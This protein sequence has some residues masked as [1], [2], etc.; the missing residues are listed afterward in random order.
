[1]K[2]LTDALWTGAPLGAADS[3]VKTAIFSANSAR[4]YGLE[5]H[6]DI[7]ARDRFA[8]KAYYRRT[9]PGRRNLHYGYVR[10]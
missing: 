10:A 3:V 5:K 8:A 1:M 7:T 4:L 9:G 6:A 2:F